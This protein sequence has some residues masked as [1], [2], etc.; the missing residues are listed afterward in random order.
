MFC[1]KI[2]GEG[3]I[4]NFD[5]FQLPSP[6]FVID[7]DLLEK[8]LKVLD[9]VQKQAGCKIIMALKGF[10]MHSVFPLV[11]E[12]LPGA[13][14]SSYNEARL[15]RDEL[16]GEVHTYCVAYN[17]K[18]FEAI[19]GIS[20]HMIFN[21]PGQ[22]QRLKPRIDAWKSL[23]KRKISCGLRVNPEYSEVKVDIYNPCA[24]GSRLGTLSENIDETSLDGIEGLH[25]HAM[26]EQGSDVLS[27]VLPEFEKRFGKWLSRMKWVNFGG[28]HHITVPG[29][30][31][32]MLVETITSFRNKWGLDVVLEPGE[33]IAINTGVLVSSV[34][35]V[36]KSGIDI[37]ILDVSASAHMPDVLE[38]PYRPA[39]NNADLPGKKKHTYRLGGPTCLAGDVIGDYSFDEPLS[40]G[41]R[42]VFADMAHYTMVKTTMFNGVHHPSIAVKRRGKGGLEVIRNFGYDDYRSRLS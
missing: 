33:A 20:D 39:V 42:I 10:A 34:L 6:C 40:P 22:W 29:Y 15:A 7:E 35:D 32:D 25:F 3:F 41:T 8:N 31:L 2:K 9:E 30:D 28:G 11:R 19:L 17:D 16:G 21:S 4:V 12:Y 38:M 24:R 37:A 27:R 23:N 13:S 36:F 18:D 14:A 1:L 26:C 5:I